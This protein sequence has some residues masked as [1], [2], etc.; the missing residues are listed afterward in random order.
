MGLIEDEE[1]HDLKYVYM[2]WER[3]REG[4]EG[5]EREREGGGAGRRVRVKRESYTHLMKDR[6]IGVQISR[7]PL[8]SWWQCFEG[9]YLRKGVR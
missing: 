6:W 1:G 3:E 9:E 8:P 5:R 2:S 7:Q 4:E